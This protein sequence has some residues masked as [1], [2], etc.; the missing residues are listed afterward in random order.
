MA[1]S[2]TIG[3]ALDMGRLQELCRS[4]LSMSRSIMDTSW[5]QVRRILLGSWA[6]ILLLCMP[7]GLFL[8]YSSGPA[9]AIFIVNFIAAVG[10]L[11]LGDTALDCIT[12]QV[13]TLNG[14]LLYI[15]TRCVKVCYIPTAQWPCG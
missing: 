9:L 14:S 3:K 4:S 1:T 6:N 10:L 12:F 11:G 8:K 2:H 5:R 7:A 13:G 15:S